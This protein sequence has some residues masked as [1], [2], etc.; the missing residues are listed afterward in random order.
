[1]TPNIWFQNVEYAVAEK[2]DRASLQLRQGGGLRVDVAVGRPHR[3][4]SGPGAGGCGQRG[5]GRGERELRLDV[6]GA[7]AVDAGRAVE[8]FGAPAR[9][10]AEVTGLVGLVLHTVEQALVRPGD[11]RL[12]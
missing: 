12:G 4:Q 1:M 10:K 2:L 9:R 11:E 8:P 5:Y 3:A 6:G 7:A